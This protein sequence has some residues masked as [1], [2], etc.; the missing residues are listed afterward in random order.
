MTD[1]IWMLDGEDIHECQSC[2]SE[3][4]LREFSLPYNEQRLGIPSDKQLLCEFCATTGCGDA[5]LYKH[6]RPGR[7]QAMMTAQAANFTVKK[8]GGFKGVKS[9]CPDCGGQGTTGGHVVPLSAGDIAVLTCTKPGQ[10]PIQRVTPER[11]CPTCK[12]VNL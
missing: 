8:L 3:A 11:V 4:P 6:L 9:N 2:T 7:N 10:L 12:G 5:T 1:Y